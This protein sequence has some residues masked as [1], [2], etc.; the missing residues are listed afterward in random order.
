MPRPGFP[1]LEVF[2]S[3]ARH[4]GSRKAALERG[5]S[6]SALSH[7]IEG[8]E[9]TPDMRF[10]PDEPQHHPGGEAPAQADRAVLAALTPST[11]ADLKGRCGRRSCA[12]QD[13]EGNAGVVEKA[14]AAAWGRNVLAVTGTG[15]KKVAKLV[16]FTTEAICRAMIL[17]ASNTAKEALS[18]ASTR[19]YAVS[20]GSP[21]RA[22][23]TQRVRDGQTV[24]LEANAAVVL[25]AVQASARSMSDL[26]TRS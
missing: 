7:V 9:Q 19:V 16:M 12:S 20:F 13:V 17:E 2:V 3:I 23:D 5:V 15:T 24:G 8:L 22:S 25:L 18:L 4:R 1:T 14:A 6:P 26:L 11:T 10:Q 21:K